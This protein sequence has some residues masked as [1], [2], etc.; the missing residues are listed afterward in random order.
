MNNSEADYICSLF[1]MSAEEFHISKQ[2]LDR[3]CVAGINY[4]KADA[5]TRG[6]FSVTPEHFADIAATAKASGLKSVFVISTC[7]RTEIYGIA[8]SVLQL[9][10]LLVP[11]TKGTKESFY[12]FAYF[13]SGEF[14]LDHLYNVAAGLDS[15]ILGDYEILGQLKKAVSISKG[16]G[17]IGPVMDR[18]LNYVYQAS[19]K[20]KTSTGLSNG[21][22]SVSFAAI[23]LLQQLPGII[24]KKALV[25]GAGKFGTNICKNLKTYLPFTPVTV[26]NRT[27]E[28]ANALALTNDIFY[29]PYCSL[30]NAI[31]NADIIIVCTNAALP[32][33]LPQYFTGN[34]EKLVLDL[35]VPMNVHP[36]VKNISG[37]TVINVDEISKT[38]LDKT[39]A[40][41]KA[42]VPKASSIIEF[43]KA[44]FRTWLRDYHYALHL[45]T[46]KDKLSRLQ[47]LQ[48]KTCEF[49]NDTEL[50]S[51]TE[52]VIR[53][54]K[55]M[56]QLAVNLKI[57]NDKGCQFINLI[58]DYL[59]SPR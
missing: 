27:D 2:V 13:K 11:H 53:A 32:T 46:W 4:H 25:I 36:D 14:A 31:D 18:M 34:A 21:T 54:Q 22:V 30:Q 20:I 5:A 33:I 8:D 57:K 29:V 51:E 44:E 17:L 26:M 45:K 3:F 40:K 37:I 48:T 43:Y 52:R 56:K 19:K 41:R 55:A 39:L 28:T 58:N 23:E 38:I 10:E 47:P 12:Q 6:T 42:E 16:Y 49:H 9:A 35:S 15:Q 1:N 59:Q 7:N 50:I 24:T